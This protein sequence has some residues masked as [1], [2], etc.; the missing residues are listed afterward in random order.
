MKNFLT[1]G[2]KLLLTEEGIAFDL[3]EQYS[4]D[5]ILDLAEKIYDAEIFY[6]QDADS[7]EK[8]KL[9]ADALGNLADKI[10]RMIPEE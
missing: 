7:N 8:N 4:E 9:R 6:A 1:D 5:D 3:A 10:Q 2:E